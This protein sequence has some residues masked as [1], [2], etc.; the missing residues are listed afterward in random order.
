MDNSAIIN[1]QNSLPVDP[2][3]F[4]ATIDGE[5]SS[6][7]WYIIIDKLSFTAAEVLGITELELL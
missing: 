3:R 1:F 5:C 6:S 7:T 4:S 2:T